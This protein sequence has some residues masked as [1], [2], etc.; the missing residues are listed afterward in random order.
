MLVTDGRNSWDFLTPENGSSRTR[1]S[2]LETENVEE[3]FFFQYFMKLQTCVN[4][5]YNFFSL[6]HQLW[7][8]IRQSGCPWQNF[9]AGKALSLSKHLNVAP[10]GSGADFWKT[11]LG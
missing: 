7:E 1:A 4:I 5:V 8:Q 10:L 3:T 9:L 11:E 6:R 2:N